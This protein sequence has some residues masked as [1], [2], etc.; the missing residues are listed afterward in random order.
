MMATAKPPSAAIIGVRGV[1]VRE[2]HRARTL[3]QHVAG[4]AEREGRERGGDRGGVV[5]PKAPRSNSP[6]TIGS[7]SDDER[8]GRRQR[9]AERDLEAARLRPA[10]V[11]ACRRCGW[12]GAKAGTS[13]GADAMPT[14]PS[15]SS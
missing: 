12:R 3:H 9:E 10:R 11:R 6:P 8:D 14:M 5:G 7:A 2:E 4:Q 13:T 15:G 1:L